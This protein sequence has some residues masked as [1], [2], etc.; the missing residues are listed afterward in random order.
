MSTIPK[1]ELHVHLEGTA[2]PELVRRIAARNGVELPEQLL[3]TDGRFRYTDFLDFLRTYDL[4][5]SVI[6]TGRGLPRHHLRVSVRVRRAAA[7]S[8][9]S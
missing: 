1:V 6:R 2:P 7:R 3:G 4:A 5:A 9:S 8:T